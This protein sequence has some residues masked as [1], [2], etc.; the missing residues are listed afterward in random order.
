[1]HAY[2]PYATPSSIVR[3]TGGFRS[4]WGATTYANAASVI[5]IAR[6]RGH[7]ILHT[8]RVLLELSPIP[9]FS[10]TAQRE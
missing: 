2:K 1:M 8:L 9:P 7:N 4:A 6:R 5:E 3:F 10:F